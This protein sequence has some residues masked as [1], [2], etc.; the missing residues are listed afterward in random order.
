MIA[1]VEEACKLAVVLAFVW[2]NR[3]FNEE[4]DGIVYVTASAIGFALFENVFYV[5]SNGFGTG[6]ARA[7]TSI[8]LHTFCGVIMGHC[9][10]RAR[11]AA[12]RATANRQI[13]GG[14]LAAVAVH[15]LYDTLAFSGTALGL[16]IVPLVIALFVVGRSLIL[17]GKALSAR[18]W[19][20]PADAPRMS[21]DTA[22]QAMAR[23]VAK[24]GTGKI[25]RTEDGRFFLKPERQPWKAI[26]ARGLFAVVA[27]GWIFIALAARGGAG[28]PRADLSEALTYLSLMSL[29]PLM[30]AILLEVSYRRRKSGNHYF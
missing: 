13:L 23:A 29:V 21:I 12:D 6:I 5:W 16:L 11:F 3:N 20:N 17:S 2:K 19:D 22:D 27:A 8:P 4:N 26:V 25:G 7:F 1:P 24:Y 15:G 28:E 9:A 18:R 10:G 14:F 30:L